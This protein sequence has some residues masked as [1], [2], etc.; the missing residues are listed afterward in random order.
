[1]AQTG[2]CYLPNEGNSETWVLT[3]TAAHMVYPGKVPAECAWH[4][5]NVCCLGPQP[6]F[7]IGASCK[8]SFERNEFGCV[9]GEDTHLLDLPFAHRFSAWHMSPKLKSVEKVSEAAVGVRFLRCPLPVRLWGVQGGDS[10]RFMMINNLIMM[11]K[12]GVGWSVPW[13]SSVLF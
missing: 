7:P 10:V 12:L 13:T 2:F 11:I 9:G 8:G 5:L 4:F 1:M 6:L 3:A